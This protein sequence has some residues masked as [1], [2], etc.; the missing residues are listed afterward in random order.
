[1]LTHTFKLLYWNIVLNFNWNIVPTLPSYPKMF[2]NM[3]A[4]PPEY[5]VLPL[6][7]SIIILSYYTLS[8]YSNYYSNIPLQSS[9]TSPGFRCKSYSGHPS[10][11]K[12]R[13]PITIMNYKYYELIASK[14]IPNTLLNIYNRTN[15]LLSNFCIG[16][17][18]SNKQNSIF[19]FFYWINNKKLQTTFLW[20]GNS[21]DNY[22]LILFINYFFS[23]LNLFVIISLE[24]L[25]SLPTLWLYT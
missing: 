7:K 3:S 2:S 20:G 1:M 23:L 21:T 5:H 4:I 15:T 8:R 12:V 13:M 22:F 16:I 11:Y 25:L 18:H 6:T 19:T 14:K 9:K 24:Y 17:A 10:S